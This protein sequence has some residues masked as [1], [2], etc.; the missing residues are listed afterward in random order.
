MKNI[1]D[2][3]GVYTPPLPT[4]QGHSPAALTLS[5]SAEG[6]WRARRLADDV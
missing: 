5:E 1:L 2:L 4:H 6:T 3:A